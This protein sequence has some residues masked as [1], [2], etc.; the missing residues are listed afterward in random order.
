VVRQA[1]SE[2]LAADRYPS[3]AEIHREVT[4]RLPS[5]ERSTSRL[6]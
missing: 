5:V 6:S 4:D 1:V 3:I 2:V